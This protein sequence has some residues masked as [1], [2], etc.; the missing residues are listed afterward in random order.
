MQHVYNQWQLYNTESGDPSKNFEEW[1]QDACLT[2]Y[3]L[4]FFIGNNKKVYI[5]YIIPPH[6]HD[7]CSWNPTPCKTRTYFFYKANIMGVDVLV[8]QGVRS[9][10]TMIL[11]M[12]NRNNSAPSR[13]CEIIL[14]DILFNSNCL[15]LGVRGLNMIR[16]IARRFMNNASTVDYAVFSCYLTVVYG[17]SWPKY[18]TSIPFHCKRDL[19]IPTNCISGQY[20]CIHG[21]GCYV[22]AN[23]RTKIAHMKQKIIS[24]PIEYKQFCFV[25]LVHVKITGAFSNMY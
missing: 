7:T 14:Q 15:L 21:S 1:C 19:I 18:H 10:A 23:T 20:A 5:I 6:W 2:L 4:F 22:T 9:S 24:Y 25:L 17:Y 8:T 16:N 12:L 11:T 3:V 13:L